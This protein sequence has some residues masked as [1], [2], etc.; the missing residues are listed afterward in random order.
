MG[1]DIYLVKPRYESA[2]LEELGGF[3]E[4]LAPGVVKGRA[5]PRAETDLVFA[6]QVLP[7]A[8]LHTEASVGLL[9]ERAFEQVAAQL[10]G[11]G[12]W[13][14][15]AFA[16]DDPDKPWREASHG[17]RAKLVR[18]RFVALMSE[19]RRRTSREETH[20]E[21][22]RYLVQLFLIDRER[23]AVSLVDLARLPDGSPWPAPWPG[24]R[25]PIQDDKSAPSRAYRKLEE[26][27][28]WC[29]AGFE[30]NQR[31]VDLGAAP[32]GWSYVALQAGAR[33]VA[34]DRAPL[35]PPASG[36]RG[37]RAVQGDAFRYEP[38]DP[39]VDW[40][41]SDV[42]AEPDKSAQLLQRWL[43]ADW[44]RRFIVHLKFKGQGHYRLAFETLRILR[45]VRPHVRAKQLVS[46]K[47]ELT[48]FG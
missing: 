40:L 6:R 36:H 5:R 39:P 48:F 8:E 21:A 2:L 34:V 29:R 28:A 30:P 10:D 4:T 32:G 42:I 41:L 27:L 16:P 24:G 14:L 46:D 12:A 43:E 18:E 33:V 44:C 7:G 1:L 26:A 23:L 38:E 9:A 25:A 3:G 19:R 13:A 22:A 47:N 20:A 17:A 11:K 37:L 35:E 31:C 45:A 15:H